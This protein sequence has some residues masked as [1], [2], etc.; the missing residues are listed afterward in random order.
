MPADPAIDD[1][2]WTDPS[3]MWLSH[4][5]PG[6]YDRCIVVRN[7]RVCRRCAVLYPVSLVAAVILG[8]GPSWPDRL[9][10][11]LLWLL[12]L[13]A[14]VEFVAEQLRL[15]EHSP[16]RLIAVTVPLA[17]AC[18]RLYVRYLDDQ[19]D[20][21]VWSVVSTYGLVCVA[22]WLLRSFGPARS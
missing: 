5:W 8:F 14:V 12:P 6:D 19:T 18:G 16:R 4:H 15:V 3:P 2:Q 11:W 13:P 9:D 22:A 10:P 7:R 17:I 21:L 1:E 20:A